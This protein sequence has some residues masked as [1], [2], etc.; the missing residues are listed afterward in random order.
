MR[1]QSVGPPKR[2]SRNN[3]VK[4]YVIDTGRQ[5]NFTLGCNGLIGQIVHDNGSRSVGTG[6]NFDVR[7]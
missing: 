7:R 6:K 3:E 2:G 1:A 4:L 5:C